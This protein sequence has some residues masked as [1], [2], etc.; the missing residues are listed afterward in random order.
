MRWSTLG[1]LLSNTTARVIYAL[2]V[3]GYVILYSDYFQTLFHFSSISVTSWG[4]LTFTQRIR[5]IYFGSWILLIAFGLYWRYAPRLLRGR[6]DEFHFVSDVVISRNRATVLEITRSAPFKNVATPRMANDEAYKGDFDRACDII[7]RAGTNLG[8]NAG[9]YEDHIPVLLSVYYRYQDLT[10]L[11]LRWLV[12]V[13]TMIGYISVLALPS[14]DLL[15]RVLGT[16]YHHLI[17]TGAG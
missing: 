7:Q 13:L 2:P 5:L 8:T 12:S 11:P 1:L 17:W 15:L 6:R 16:E 3:A 4:F 9:E 10:A 14:L